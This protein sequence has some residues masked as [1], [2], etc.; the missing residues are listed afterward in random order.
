MY[1]R[2]SEL[3][4]M[5]D[6]TSA[7]DKITETKFWNRYFSSERTGI[8][9]SNKKEILHR[10]D[11]VIYIEDGEVKSLSNLNNILIEYPEACE[12]LL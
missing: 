6:T 7:L 5:D 3:L 2:N 10:A 8:I 4:F 12:F 9:V 1:A 11:K